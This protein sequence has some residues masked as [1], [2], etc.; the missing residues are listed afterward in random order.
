MSGTNVFKSNH[1]LYYLS[2]G[3]M[4]GMP[5]SGVV[6]SPTEADWATF[7]KEIESVGVFDWHN[8]QQEWPVAD[9]SREGAAACGVSSL[10]FYICSG[11]KIAICKGVSNRYPP[12]WSEFWKCVNKLLKTNSRPLNQEEVSSAQSELKALWEKTLRD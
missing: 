6:Y 1:S 11:E 3:Y 8:K 12:E 5:Q 9:P 2:L 7:W 4:P 10:H